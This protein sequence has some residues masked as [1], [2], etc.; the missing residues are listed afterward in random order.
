MRRGADRR[1]CAPGSDQADADLSHAT[2]CASHGDGSPAGGRAD[3]NR[4]RG[5]RCRRRGGG[6]VPPGPPA[7]GRRRW[8]AVRTDTP[9]CRRAAAAALPGAHRA[10]SGTPSP[11]PRRT[12]GDAAARGGGRRADDDSPRRHPV[13]RR[14]D[15]LGHRRRR[16]ADAPSA[17]AAGRRAGAFC[18]RT[19][20]CRPPPAHRSSWSATPAP[21]P[22]E[23]CPRPVC[24]RCGK[25]P[26]SETTFTVLSQAHRSAATCHSAGS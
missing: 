12:H 1:C 18:S 24:T 19:T 26:C 15:P 5:R 21:S 3:A 23:P 22:A 2:G 11:S 25:G 8:C 16:A 13:G 20:H 9:G 4:D 6:A 7:D 17:R 10:T 14:C